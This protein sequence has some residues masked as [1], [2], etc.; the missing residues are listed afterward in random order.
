MTICLHGLQ[1]FLG[2]REKALSEKH[3][4]NQARANINLEQFSSALRKWTSLVPKGRKS[5]QQHWSDASTLLCATQAISVFF[6]L[7][8]FHFVHSRATSK[9]KRNSSV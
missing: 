5:L 8:N 2:I 3:N 6:L 4:Y 1:S 7:L 9:E